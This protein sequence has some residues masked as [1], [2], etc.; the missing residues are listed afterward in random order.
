MYHSKLLE[1]FRKLNSEEIRKLKK[2]VVSPYFFQHDDVVKLYEYLFSKKYLSENN[3]NRTKI[4]Q[5]LYGDIAY[6]DA[7]LRYITSLATDVLEQFFQ[8]ER[9]NKNEV[10]NALSISKTL[11]EK[12]LSAYADTFLQKAISLHQQS[13]QQNAT[14]W[15]YAFHL[16]EEIFKQSNQ[17]SRNKDNN[18]QSIIHTLDQY[19]ITQLLKYACVAT[20]YQQI[21]QQDYQ[22]L[23][24]QTILDIAKKDETILN[25]SALIYYKIY[26]LYTANILQY[27]NDLL[28]LLPTHS[29]YF[30]TDELKDI[31]LLIINFGIKQLNSGN[32]SFAQKLYSMYQS[33]LQ[34]SVFI[35]N[36]Q[37]S[38]FTFT[39]IVFTGLQTGDFAGVLSFIHLHEKYLPENFRKSTIG[40]NKAR[41]H[42]FLKEYKTALQYLTD[43]E[44]NDI[45]QNLAVKNMQLK[46]YV[47]TQEWETLDSF[48][49]TFSVFLHRQKGLGYHQLNYKNT[50]KFA[51]RLAEVHSS[52][53]KIRK[54]LFHEIQAEKNILDKEWFLENIK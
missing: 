1:I 52:S 42:Y 27:F 36:E 29:A 6:D 43:Y 48:L 7:R 45:L 3:T 40:F 37:I 19:Y 17:Q 54:M 20:S 51:R 12:Q 31:Y 10:N 26:Q 33:G 22:Y 16:E 46:I 47:E 50:I 34:N 49:N 38:R 39:N 32:T 5:Y 15:Q 35:E 11:H 30:A 13:T 4:F 2:F 21:I 14:H 24:L 44:Y 8:I 41:Y 18:I 53:K 25:K 28:Q 23:L 9:N